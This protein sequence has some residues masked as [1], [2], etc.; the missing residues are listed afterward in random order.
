MNKL[1]F[2][3][4]NQKKTFPLVVLILFCGQ[5]S[6]SCYKKRPQI[7]K[8]HFTISIDLIPYQDHT[9]QIFY[10]LNADDSYY[11]ELSLKKNVKANTTLQNLVFELPHGIK[12]KNIRIDLDEHENDSIRVENIRFQYKNLMVNGNR[13]VYKSWFTFNENITEGKDSLTFHLKR[14]NNFLD[15]QLN[16]NRK[17]NAKLVKLFL[18]DI[19]DKNPFHRDHKETQKNVIKI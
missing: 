12:P 5:I 14:V 16:G 10:K 1:R 6:V 3:I 2:S 15:P 8:H 18:P 4:I 19:Y 9:I 11:E 7:E 17:L 13:G